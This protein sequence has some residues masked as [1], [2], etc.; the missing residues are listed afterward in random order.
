[1]VSRQGG[2]Q[3]QGFLAG[4][5]AL[6]EIIRQNAKDAKKNLIRLS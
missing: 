4:F 5:A 2:K 6:R 1:M 3:H